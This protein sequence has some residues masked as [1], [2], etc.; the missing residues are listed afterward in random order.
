MTASWATA[1]RR[2]SQ[3]EDHPLEGHQESLRG[4]RGYP[5]AIRPTPASTR[6][7]I[8]TVIS[9]PTVA[10]RRS[11]C[12]GAAPGCCVWIRCVLPSG[13]PREESR[14][15]RGKDRAATAGATVRRPP[16]A[17]KARS[18]RR[19]S[20]PRLRASRLTTTRKPRPETGPKPKTTSTARVVSRTAKV[21]PP[22]AVATCRLA[23]NRHHRLAMP[24][25]RFPKSGGL[26]TWLS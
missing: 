9:A 3:A 14:R 25:K 6:R 19:A 2:H 4:L 18:R 12:W 21:P 13:I 1:P 22:P 16:T 5:T 23:R 26:L 7:I 24:W 17:T 15:G 11:R 8:G 20:P 10:P